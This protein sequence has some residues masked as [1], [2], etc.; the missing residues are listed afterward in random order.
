MRKYIFFILCFSLLPFQLFAADAT[1]QTYIRNQSID[2]WVAIARGALQDPVDHASLRAL[3]TGSTNDLSKFILALVANGANPQNFFGRNYVVDL[4]AEAKDNQIGSPQHLNDDAW[5]LL[6]LRAAGL[7]LDYPAVSTT[8]KNLLL[9][10]NTD[11]GWGYLVGGKSDTND[12]AAIMMALL[13]AGVSPIDPSLQRA[14]GYLAKQ[15]NDDGGFSY[16][17]A[18]YTVSDGASDAWVISALLKMGSDLNAWKK[19]GVTPRDHL[20]SLARPDGCYTWQSGGLNCSLGVTAQA[21]IAAEGKWYPVRG[22]APSTTPIAVPLPPAYQ[23]IVPSSPIASTWSGILTGTSAVSISSRKGGETITTAPGTIVGDKDSDGDG[24]SDA[25]EIARGYDPY[26]PAPCLIPVYSTKLK[27]SY[28]GA[29]LAHPGDEACRARYVRQQLEKTLGQRLKISS[30]AFTTLTN[31]YLYGGYD[32]K[33]LAMAAKG[34][35]TVHP[36]IY[37][38]FWVRRNK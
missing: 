3:S 26:D 1:M 4:L 2:A 14:L 9:T 31:A 36:T 33:D 7:S 12:T 11:G 20:R 35:K 24:Y 38:E 29:R 28:G 8:R 18:Q 22:G 19:N 27:N 6:A 5:G 25:V 15:Q 30:R 32:M 17:H 21:V 23:P 16:D 13:E 34:A 37:K 10:Q